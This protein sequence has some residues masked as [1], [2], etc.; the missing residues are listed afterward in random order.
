[1]P[2][3]LEQRK[4]VLLRRRIGIEGQ[5]EDI[6]L[7]LA[8]ATRVCHERRAAH[9]FI[10]NRRA[11]R[12]YQRR[13]SIRAPHKRRVGVRPVETVAVVQSTTDRRRRPVNV[14]GHDRIAIPDVGDEKSFFVNRVVVFRADRCVGI[15]HSDG[16]AVL[17]NVSIGVGNADGKGHALRIN[18]TSRG[19]KSPFPVGTYRQR[20]KSCRYRFV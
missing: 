19:L 17:V 11:A 18:D 6:W 10:G 3:R 7:V 13:Q 16:V 20:T 12:R 4:F 5:F 1:M 8:S 15:Q 14:A 2:E 9:D